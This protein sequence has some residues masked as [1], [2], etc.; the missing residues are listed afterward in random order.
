[1]AQRSSALSNHALRFHLLQQP[2][3]GNGSPDYAYWI[4]CLMPPLDWLE[5]WEQRPSNGVLVASAGHEPHATD[6]LSGLA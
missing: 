2:D 3:W 6:N 5:M 1:M 4:G